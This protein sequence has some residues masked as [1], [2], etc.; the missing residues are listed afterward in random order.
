MH[1][2]GKLLQKPVCIATR[3]R[4]L[5]SINTSLVGIV[6]VILASASAVTAA[7]ASDARII[8]ALAADAYVWGLGPEY[9]ERFSRYN[10][11]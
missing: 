4:S 2:P 10:L 7:P 8:K 1:H 3:V 11:H 9:I 6:C 5:F